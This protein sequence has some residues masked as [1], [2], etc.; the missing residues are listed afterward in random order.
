MTH[1]PT[2]RPRSVIVIPRETVVPGDDAPA[3]VWRDRHSEAARYG[4]ANRIPPMNEAPTTEK[5]VPPPERGGTARAPKKPP[6][7]RYPQG[8]EATP[9][10]TLRPDPD[11]FY[12][13]I[14]D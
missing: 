4:F 14:A 12:G 9:V 1:E 13:D 8:E 3:S 11:F 10:E 6:W 5:A 7:P 2:S